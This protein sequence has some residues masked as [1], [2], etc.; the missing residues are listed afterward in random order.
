L[1]SVPTFETATFELDV[2]VRVR[3]FPTGKSNERGKSVSD[4]VLDM[5][6]PLRLQFFSGL[7]SKMISFGKLFQNLNR[8]QTLQ[9]W[10]AGYGCVNGKNYDF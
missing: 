6:L 3:E 8:I 9:L 10:G 7:C 5:A 4:R 2:V 1:D